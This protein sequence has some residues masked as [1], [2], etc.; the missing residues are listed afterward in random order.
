MGIEIVCVHSAAFAFGCGNRERSYTRKYIADFLPFQE[1]PLDQSFVLCVQSGVPIDLGEIESEG[2]LLFF[3]LC[4]Q[5]IGFSSNN[6]HWK[7]SEFIL[8]VANLVH[9][10]LQC[11]I[12]VQ[13]HLSN[14]CFEWNVLLQQV[15]VCNVSNGL[16]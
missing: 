10:S 7:D 2:A 12:L 15:N 13:N 16:K 14:Q 1:V 11:G 4:N 8:N 9:Y 3:H 5:E 6:F